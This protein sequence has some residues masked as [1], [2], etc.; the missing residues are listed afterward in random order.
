[1]PRCSARGLGAALSCLGNGLLWLRG[2]PGHRGWP[3]PAAAPLAPPVRMGA[4]EPSPGAESK[5]ASPVRV[6]PASHLA[7]SLG[8]DEWDPGR[9]GK[10]GKAPS[11]REHLPYPMMPQQTPP[12][13]AHTDGEWG[14]TLL[15]AISCHTFFFG[16]ILSPSPHT[17][18]RASCPRHPCPM[19]WGGR[20]PTFEE[21]ADENRLEDRKLL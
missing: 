9:W 2:R 13:F 14:E 16:V 19:S 8:K 4:E 20:S 1:M 3:A 21:V 15:W 17:P 7:L 18:K 10:T 12:F 11:R 6:A 5:P